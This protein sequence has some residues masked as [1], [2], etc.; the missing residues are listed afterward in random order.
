[1]PDVTALLSKGLQGLGS[2]AG[3]AAASASEAVRSGQA[4]LQEK[5][6]VEKAQALAQ[7]RGPF[8]QEAGAAGMACTVHCIAGCVLLTW[9]HLT[10]SGE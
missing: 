10:A 1:V 8:T 2:V 5:Q 6:V 3:V 9:P 7:V 4:I